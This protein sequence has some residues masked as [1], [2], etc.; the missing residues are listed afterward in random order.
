[1]RTAREIL[2]EAGLPPPPKGEDRY[3][4]ICPKC[5]AGRSAAHR[6]IKCL[7]ITITA[8]GAQWGCNHCDFKGGAYYNG[9]DSDPVI[10]TYDYVDESGKILFR[11]LRTASKKF[12]QQHPDGKGR[13]VSGIKNIPRVL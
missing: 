5:S 2:Q 4:A 3:Y 9:K 11:K 7:G 6:K 12:W 1:M 8:E 10:A 13:W